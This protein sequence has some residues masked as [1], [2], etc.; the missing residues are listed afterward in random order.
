M[1]FKYVCKT[2]GLGLTEL[3]NNRFLLTLVVISLKGFNLMYAL[4][5]LKLQ[6]DMDC[7]EN[8]SIV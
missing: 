8:Q 3:K 5:W 6:I 4:N 2:L 1:H 7:C